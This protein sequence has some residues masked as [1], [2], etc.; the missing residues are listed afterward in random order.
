MSIHLLCAVSAIYGTPAYADLV[1]MERVSYRQGYYALS[2]LLIGDDYTPSTIGYDALY[3]NYARW[4]KVYIPCGTEQRVVYSLCNQWLNRGPSALFTESDWYPL[5]KVKSMTV[6]NYTRA[7]VGA[8]GAV[9][10][11]VGHTTPEIEE[12]CEYILLTVKD[13]LRQEIK[14]PITDA[15]DRLIA[16]RRVDTQQKLHL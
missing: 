8:C 15:V 5:E 12:L 14:T 10:S 16:Q 11:L 9:R 7:C 6:T 3:R 13:I 2:D 1:R 4:D